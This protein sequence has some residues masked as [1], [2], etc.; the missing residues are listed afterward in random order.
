MKNLFKRGIIFLLVFIL[1]TGDMQVLAASNEEKVTINTFVEMLVKS[2]KLKVDSTQKSPYIKTA[3]DSGIVIDGQFLSYSKY[4]KREDAAV[5]VTRTYE[6]LYGKDY[7]QD[8]YAQVRD[9]KRLSDLGKVQKDNIGAI[10]KCFVRGLMEGFSNGLYKQN[11]AFKGIDYLTLKDAKL[12]V[13]RI[14]DTSKRFKLSFDGQLIRTTNLPK[15]YKKYEYILESFPN[16]FYEKKF[17]YQK[18]K[19]YY[20]PIELVDYAPPS[21]F[22]QF[23][24]EWVL[25][26]Y[27]DSWMKKVETNLNTRLNVD[28]RTVDANWINTLRGTYYMFNDNDYDLKYTKHIENYVKTMKKNKVII[29]GSAVVEP[30]TLYFATGYYVRCRIKFMVV[31]ATNLNVDEEDIIYGGNVYLP[32]LR[33]GVWREL[34]CD[35]QIGTSNGLSDGR[36]F[37]VT[38]DGLYED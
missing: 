22:N 24:D 18:T 31:S 8:L 15:N 30:S 28:Y 35:I 27:L 3:I 36:D 14:T 4:I 2:A 9:K 1:V 6:L 7:D 12:T 25:K 5:L 34:V 21:K 32:N 19:Y 33:K 37:S 23:F 13:S 16:S 38:N 20:E 10:R 17:L 11:R 26:A 29:K